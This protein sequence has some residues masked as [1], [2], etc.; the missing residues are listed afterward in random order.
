MKKQLPLFW[1]W[2][3]KH[4]QDFVRDRERQN[5]LCV[6]GWRIL[7]FSAGMIYQ[8]LPEQLEHVALALATGPAPILPDRVD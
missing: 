4:K 2:H 8:Q 6:H 7:R 1:Q 5:L 3:G